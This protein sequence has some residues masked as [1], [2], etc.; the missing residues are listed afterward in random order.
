VAAGDPVGTGLVA[1]LARPG[2]NATGLSNQSPDLAAKRI[3]LLHEA[4][5]SLG[6]LAVMANPGNPFT[7]LEMLDAQAA[8]RTLGLEVVTLEIRRSEDIAPAFEALKG[9]ADALYVVV[10]TLVNTNR[11]RINTLALAARRCTAFGRSSN[12][13]V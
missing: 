8:A 12:P 13:E 3:D 10:D 4:I 5:P 1:S 2:G 11:V 6:R 9:N 7:M